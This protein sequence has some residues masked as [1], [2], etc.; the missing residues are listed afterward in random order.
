MELVLK[1]RQRVR[2]FLGV[3]FPFEVLL[4][5]GNSGLD[6]TTNAWKED[7]EF[8]DH[9]IAQIY[10]YLFICFLH[11]LLFSNPPVYIPDKYL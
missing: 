2:Y 1:E 4:G 7:K 9:H 10:T 5:S 11:L 8:L 6:E 3:E